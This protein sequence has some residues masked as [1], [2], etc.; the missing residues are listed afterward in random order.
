MSEAVLP[1]PEKQVA[2]DGDS[3][4]A[5]ESINNSL[6]TSPADHVP[7]VADGANEVTDWKPD[8]NFW[9][10]LSPLTLLALMV[11]LDG[12]SVSVALP[13]IA[14]SLHGTAIEAFWTGTSFLLSSAVFQLPIGAFSDIFGRRIILTICTALFLIGII[15]S[16]VSNTFTPMLVGRTIQ[17][18]GGG[19]VILLNDIVITDLVPMRQR[20][21]YFGII[22]AIWGV[23]SVTGPV[24]GGAFAIGATWRWLFWINIPFAG[25]SL[26]LVPIFLRLNRTPGSIAHRL[27]RVDW[28]GSV[29]FVA[30]STSLLMPLTWGGVMYSWSSWQTLLPLLLGIFGLVGFGFYEAY[31]PAEPI[32][33]VGLLRNYNLAYSLFGS[34]INAA[35]VYAALY[36]MPLYFEAVQ[37]YS[38]VI[39][40]VALFPATFTVAPMSVVAG[41]IISKTGDF[42]VVTWVGWL[43]CTVGMGVCTLLDVGTSVQKWFFLTFTTGIG[44]GL[45][46]TSL[47][48]VN[49]AGAADKL[50]ASAISLFIFSR[51]LGQA[52]GVGISGVIFQNQ[53]RSNLLQTSLASMADDYSRDASSLVA[54]L[55]DMPGGPQRDELLQAY[56]DSLKIVWAVMCALSGVAGIGS[57][58]M[59]K[60]NENRWCR[61]H[62]TSWVQRDMKAETSL[63]RLM[64]PE[65]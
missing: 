62:E 33:K 50:M 3:A 42:R 57:I 13:I 37:G 56:A 14:D 8:R 47:A 7:V 19:G 43:A 35:L 59:K 55:K 38:P 11:S 1:G 34:C 2:T 22:G 12:T 24:I 26:I 16:S 46:Y 53:M 65:W 6:T 54:T 44:L 40:G 36:F 31:V 49:Q 32:F 9:L 39:S 58:F 23:G 45:L 63:L 52:L 5:D 17:G 48:I 29:L 28:V 64:S 18:V 61:E 41:V 15:I 27:A 4:K 25:I 21:A 20:G 10:A 60:R 30:A 51:M